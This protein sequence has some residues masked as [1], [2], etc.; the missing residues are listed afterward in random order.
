M[1]DKNNAVDR[2]LRR[3]RGRVV[4]TEAAR[5]NFTAY[6]RFVWRRYQHARHLDLIDRALTKVIEYVE[7]Y[8]GTG[9]GRLM[10]NLPPRH[11]K[12]ATVATL[13]P[14]Y[15]LGRNPDHRVILASY[16][17]TLAEKNS[18]RV[19]ELIRGADHLEVFP[20]VGLSPD[21]GARE[22]WDLSAPHEGGMDAVGKGGG[23]TGKGAQL[24]ILDDM[25][26]SRQEVE[27]A[28]MR[29]NDWDWYRNDLLSRVEPGGAIVMIA[30]RWHEDD[31][32]GRI[33]TTEG[34]EWETII[35][36]AL[37]EENDPMGR[38]VG[39]P[40]WP[41]RYSLRALEKMKRTM[42]DYVWTAL[43]QQRPRP[44]EGGLFKTSIM[45]DKYLSDPPPD[46]LKRVR[47]WDIAMSERSTANYSAGVLMGY[48]SNGNIVV[49]DVVHRQ[50]EW[51]A[52]PDLIM[53]V[54]LQDGPDV[55]VGIEAVFYQA[56]VVMNLLKR[57]ELSRHVIR[58]FPVEG[59]KFSRALPWSARW[60][61][62][63]VYVLR[64][65]WTHKYIEEH[66][67]F[68]YGANDDQVDA[69]SGC[70][71]AL[72]GSMQSVTVVRQKIMA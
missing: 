49:L 64:R 60:G 69:S 70:L 59:D 6:K 62:G 66:A 4:T 46:V 7:S 61:A 39:E 45:H 26:K 25:V 38:A 10:I 19:R 15:F 48:T 2:A 47:F 18:R 65:T 28:Y 41:E 56:S 21:S 13:L 72:T 37:A 9:I 50:V 58:S 42:G 54:A 67:S 11:G 55:H 36:P 52:V 12:T 44:R 71:Q 31:I 53:R 27:S 17:A 40:L 68:P 30:T 1:I 34:A 5:Q 14:A 3:V 23:I 33:L 20:G 24:I 22:S 35:L 63:Q 29:D 43:Y 51:S 32:A 16:G 57:P 8:G